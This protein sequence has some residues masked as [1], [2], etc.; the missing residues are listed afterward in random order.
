MLWHWRSVG[1]VSH[2]PHSPGCGC[3]ALVERILR[4]GFDSASERRQWVE[5]NLPSTAVLLSDLT[6]IV[7]PTARIAR[8]KVRRVGIS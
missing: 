1:L 5:Q 6:D 3:L 7:P 8:G 2:Y 4:R